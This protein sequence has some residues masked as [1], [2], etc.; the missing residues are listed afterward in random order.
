MATDDKQDALTNLQD[1]T[2]KLVAYSIISLKR[3]EEKILDGGEGSVIVTD[4]MTGK[5][6]TS[7][8]IAQYLQKKMDDPD[9]PTKK[10][11]ISRAELLKRD[12]TWKARDMK[13]WRVYYVVSTRWPR[14]PLEFEQRQISVLRE[15]RDDISRQ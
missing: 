14:Q 2:V 13:Y 9:D 1:D 5:A 3:D 6:F 11:K 4:S 7:M 8:I 15:I 12:R 10:K